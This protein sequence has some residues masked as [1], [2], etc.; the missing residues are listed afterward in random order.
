MSSKGW[1]PVWQ[2]SNGRTNI[3]PDA[4]YQDAR[5]ERWEVPS[6]VACP[7]G[8]QLGAGRVL[9]GACACRCGG[10]RTWLCR[11]CE[12]MVI[13]PPETDECERGVF[14]RRAERAQRDG[15]SLGP[16]ASQ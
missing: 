9:V 10:H 2:I 16:V 3:N 12:A 15:T 4:L 6:P 14:D 1:R 8:H 5:T 7:N 13:W 11:T